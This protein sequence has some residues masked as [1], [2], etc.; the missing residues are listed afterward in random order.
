MLYQLRVPKKKSLTDPVKLIDFPDQGL[1][2]KVKKATVKPSSIPPQKVAEKVEPKILKTPS[3]QLNTSN[4]SINKIMQKKEEIQS[5][6]GL[7]ISNM[8]RNDY[9]H[10]DFIMRWKRFAFQMKE[11]GKETFY[12]AMIKR[13]PKLKSEHLYVMEVDNQIQID[14]IKPTLSDLISYIRKELKN[15]QISI[16]MTLSEKPDEEVKFQTG[17][18]KFK[19]LA[20]KNPNLHSLKNTFNLDIDF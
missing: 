5:S 16:E 4:L 11:K 20:R 14:Y 15:Y 12:N 1:R 17:K 7:D 8:P 6:E 9:Q 13:D 18:D 10:D 19:A 3:G 2:K